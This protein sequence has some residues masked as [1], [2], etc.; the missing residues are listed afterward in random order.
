MQNYKNNET[1]DKK[2][3]KKRTAQTLKVSDDL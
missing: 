2:S 3:K 1:M